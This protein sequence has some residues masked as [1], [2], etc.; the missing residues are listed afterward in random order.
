MKEQKCIHE[1]LI[2]ESLPNGMF[3]VRLDDEDLILGY[4]SGRIRHNIESESH[5]LEFDSLFV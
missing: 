4:V 5:L 2:N 1:G 3:W